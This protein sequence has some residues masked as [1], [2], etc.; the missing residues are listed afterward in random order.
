MVVGKSW[1]RAPSTPPGSWPKQRGPDVQRSRRG[2]GRQGRASGGVEG[3]MPSIARCG[4]RAYPMAGE[5]TNRHML[6]RTRHGCPVGRKAHGGRSALGGEQ[7]RRPDPERMTAAPASLPDGRRGTD[8]V[9][10]R[11][12]PDLA[13]ADV[14]WEVT[15]VCPRGPAGGE[16]HASGA[17]GAERTPTRAHAQQS[18]APTCTDPRTEGPPREVGGSWPGA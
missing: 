9:E 2:S 1:G 16:V 15:G 3:P 13:Q 7:T 18:L 12:V 8:R 4:R 17:R 14:L 5:G 6:G 11:A 10:C